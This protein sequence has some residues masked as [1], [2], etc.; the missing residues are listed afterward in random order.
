MAQSHWEGCSVDAL[1]KYE[2]Q[3]HLLREITF[4]GSNLSCHELRASHWRLILSL[5]NLAQAQAKPKRM[6]KYTSD[7]NYLKMPPQST[8]LSPNDCDVPTPGLPRASLLLQF[9]ALCCIYMES[10]VGNFNSRE[11]T[12]SNGCLWLRGPITEVEMLTEDLI[13]SQISTP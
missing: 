9:N 1:A 6:P 13:S 7:T 5:R 12:E 2:D 8:G 11:T 4:D 10:P 3:W